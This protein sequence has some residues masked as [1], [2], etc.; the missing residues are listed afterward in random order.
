MP[1][2]M[3]FR[4]DC[5]LPVVIQTPD[6]SGEKICNNVFIADSYYFTNKGVENEKEIICTGSVNCFD[7]GLLW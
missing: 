2:N 4:G 3:V 5:P 7:D 1:V 6:W